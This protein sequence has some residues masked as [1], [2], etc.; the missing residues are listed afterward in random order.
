MLNPVRLPRR[1][2][3]QRSAMGFGLLGLRG[4]F[5]SMASAETVA[6]NPLAPKPPHF[7][8][9]AKRIIFLFMHG[10][11]S[12]IDTFDPKPRLT[13]DNGK[14][15]PFK[16]GL[17]FGEDGVRGLMKSPWSFK[18]YGASG[19]P[20]SELF[21]N[22][23]TCVD[24]LCVIRSMV[25]DGVDHG[26]ALLQLHTGVF[27][28]RRPS[29]GSWSLY[30]LGTENQNLPGFITIKPTLGHGGQN[31]WSSSF[32][33]GQ[34]Q[35][36]PI[37]SSDMK[38]EEIEKEPMPWLKSRGFTGENQRFELDMIQKINRRHA[39]A[40]DHDPELE[41]RIGALEL[42]FRM[43]LE[44]PEAFDVAKESEATRKLYGL[45]SETTRDFGWQCLL[46]RRL[47]ERGVRF[48]Q[49]SHS[50]KW[51]QHTDLFRLHT[52]NAAEVDKPIA[53][54]LKDLKARGLLKDTLVIWGGEFGRTPWA[55][56]ADGRDHNPYGYT[57]WMAGGGVKPGFVYGA[58]DEFGYHAVDNRM[59]IHDMHA[60][61]L[62]LMGLDHLKLTYRFA[63]RDFRL[64]DVAGSVANG[65]FA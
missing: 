14:P 18:P 56:G 52:K 43:Q 20:V 1:V 49:A 24:D 54:L 48:V 46:A 63:G 40:N 34:Y 6:N 10:G 44:A 36:T 64:T 8:P 55:Q 38:I 28:F 15:V 29:M 39:A 47:S 16:R 62:A 22:V 21:P 13:A 32:L 2:L 45:D 19:I 25:G 61:I 37:G 12:S 53:G 30:G 23:A 4:L 33:P 31:N 27:S 3:L 9:R 65:V 59:H 58:T 26:A 57:I 35:G 41:A 60:T 17:T 51:D 7:A 11:P 50:Y 5:G 42:A